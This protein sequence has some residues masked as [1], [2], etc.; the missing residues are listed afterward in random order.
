[1]SIDAIESALK[2]CLKIKQ[3]LLERSW[4]DKIV[5]TLAIRLRYRLGS[6]ATRA[7]T[8]R[9]G[10]IHIHISCVDCGANCYQQQESHIKS[11]TSAAKVS[12]MQNIISQFRYVFLMSALLMAVTLSGST[13]VYAQKV[14]VAHRGASGYLP[15]HTLEAKAMAY[16]MGADYLEQDVVMTKD[17]Q[18]LVLHDIT[19]ERTTDVA[20]RF[21]NR[22]RSDGHYYAIDFTLA[23]LRQLRVNEGVREEVNTRSAVYPER[24]PVDASS[25]RL[26]T[27]EEEIE[28]IQ[29]MNKSTGRDVGIYLETKKPEFHRA[30][31]KDLSTAVINVLKRYGY[32]TKQ[33]K[34]FVQT[35]SYE[36]LKILHEEVLPAAGVSL[37]LVQLID[38]EATYGWMLDAQGMKELARYADGL[39]PEK[40]MII[41]RDST[42]DDIIIND[43]VELAHANGMQVHPYTF[44]A[45]E[46]QVP[47]FA[48]NFEEL[49]DLYYFDANVD[50]VFTDFPD[51]AVNFLRSK[52][53]T[54]R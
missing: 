41:D 13:R 12:S 26:N 51:K 2:P 47:H 15:E 54:T 4:N 14:V 35:F 33:H 10:D 43:L 40:S 18:L 45:D 32:T 8:A 31:G 7:C 49:L 24:F 38:G 29:G 34:V 6:Q 46:G 36:E 27:L 5:D 53:R 28:F 20:S 44:R 30:E 9:G 42:P 50:G 16:A 22:A 1:M 39:G 23:E 37:N 25:F 17:D 19:L 52:A 21:A 48:E 3:D 11:H